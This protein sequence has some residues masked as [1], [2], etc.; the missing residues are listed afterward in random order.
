VKPIII[1]I[2]TSHMRI[3]Y[4]PVEM[5]AIIANEYQNLVIACKKYSTN[6]KLLT[7]YILKYLLCIKCCSNGTF[8]VKKLYMIYLLNTANKQQQNSFH[9]IS[10]S[11]FWNVVPIAVKM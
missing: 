10:F 6:D 9:T 1:C 2:N 11:Q 3:L 5:N 7:K 4:I 8:E